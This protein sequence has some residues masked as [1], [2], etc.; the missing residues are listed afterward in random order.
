MASEQ[1]LKRA[2][3][4]GFKRE[5]VI[6]Y[7]EKLQIQLSDSQ[8]KTDSLRKKAK[9][10]EKLKKSVEEKDSIID[11]LNNEIE[12]LKNENDTNQQ[13]I[14]LLNDSI[15]SERTVFDNIK[16]T[17]AEFEEKRSE[18]DEVLKTNGSKKSEKLTVA[19][20]SLVE[21][22]DSIS[23]NF[24]KETNDEDQFRFDIDGL[25]KVEE[26]FLSKK[27]SEE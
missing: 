16:K 23:S 20:K 2:V 17:C 6:D 11:S 24:E 19:V 18:I 27:I 12:Q 21:Y 26:E 5:D 3:F 25:A 14:Y 9:A 4:G 8:K 7:I 1:I 10:S 13:T 22:L 15:S